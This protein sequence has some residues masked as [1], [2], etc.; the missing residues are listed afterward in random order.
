[1]TP[2]TATMTAPTTMTGMTNSASRLFVA[3][4]DDNLGDDDLVNFG[5]T[6]TKDRT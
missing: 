2:T 6:I 1:M 5:A 4:F 3:D